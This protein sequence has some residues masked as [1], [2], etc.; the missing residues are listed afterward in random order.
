MDLP[1]FFHVV[2]PGKTRIR[3]NVKANSAFFWF[4]SQ[5]L[6]GLHPC[7]HLQKLCLP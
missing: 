1:L 3:T 5:I 7:L 6:A 2:K 4:R